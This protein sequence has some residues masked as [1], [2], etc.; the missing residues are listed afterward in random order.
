VR[1]LGVFEKSMRKPSARVCVGWR[2][3][4]CKSSW[5]CVE[6]RRGGVTDCRELRRF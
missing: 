4:A 1:K 3:N 5:K 2:R 6:V